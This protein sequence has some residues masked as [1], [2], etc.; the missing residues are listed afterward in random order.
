VKVKIL[1]QRR[2]IFRGRLTGRT[3][4]FK[5]H[6]SKIIFQKPY[7][8]KIEDRLGAGARIP[9]EISTATGGFGAVTGT[10]PCCC[11]W[12]FTRSMSTTSFFDS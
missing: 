11:S 10:V 4:S 1:P 3:S 6:R 2:P 7:R 5:N 9:P 8:S 12:R